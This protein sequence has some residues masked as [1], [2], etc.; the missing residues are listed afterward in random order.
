MSFIQSFDAYL[1]KTQTAETKQL[2]G[3]KCW[4]GSYMAHW[5]KS[6]RGRN[7]VP[8]GGN[9]IGTAYRNFLKENSLEEP[10]ANKLLEIYHWLDQ[11]PD[12][13]PDYAYQM[14]DEIK[15]W[16]RSGSLSNELFL[17]MN[18]FFVSSFESFLEVKIRQFESDNDEI[19]VIHNFKHLV[20]KFVNRSFSVE[21]E[22]RED[23]VFAFV[24]SLT[25]ENH[26]LF[27]YL[28]PLVKDFAIMFRSS[29]SEL[30]DKD[31]D[32]EDAGDSMGA[33]LFDSL[34][35]RIDNWQVVLK[36]FYAEVFDGPRAISSTFRYWKKN[37]SLPLLI[38][39]M[40]SCMM[41]K[42][43]TEKGYSAVTY[44]S[45]TGY[46]QVTLNAGFDSVVKG[47][48]DNVINYKISTSM[49]RDGLIEPRAI[50]SRDSN[51]KLD[52]FETLFQQEYEALVLGQI[53]FE[54]SLDLRYGSDQEFGNSRPGVIE[55]ISQYQVR[56]WDSGGIPTSINAFKLMRKP[57]TT[58]VSQGFTNAPI[59]SSGYIH[60][61]N[62][63]QELPRDMSGKIILASSAGTEYRKVVLSWGTKYAPAG[64]LSK[65][66][67][68]T[69]HVPAVLAGVMLCGV[70]VND[71]NL[72]HG[73][74]VTCV[75]DGGQ[76]RV[77]KEDIPFEAQKIPFADIPKTIIKTG[78][79]LTNAGWCD[80]DA[81]LPDVAKVS[82][83]RW[84]MGESGLIMDKQQVLPMPCYLYYSIMPENIKKIIDIQ[85][86]GLDPIEFY[87]LVMV[88][89]FGGVLDSFRGK[90]VNLRL[91]D[92]RVPAEANFYLPDSIFKNPDNP[93]A[94]LSGARLITQ[95]GEL[96]NQILAVVGE[97]FSEL[98]IRGFK[99]F[100]PMLPNVCYADLDAVPIVN[101]L[102]SRGISPQEFDYVCMDEVPELSGTDIHGNPIEYF[103]L[104]D[105][106]FK[107]LSEGN[108]DQSTAQSKIARDQTPLYHVHMAS[109]PNTFGRYYRKVENANKAGLVL[110]SCGNAHPALM[111]TFQEVG[112]DSVGLPPGIAYNE[113]KK[114]LN[115][116]EKEL[117][118]NLP[119]AS[120][121]I[122][123]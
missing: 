98:K 35:A 34:P 82:L 111:R 91:P 67:S 20:Q 19:I 117:A 64:F 54:Q 119:L 100:C 25:G 62:S 109:H 39:N 88:E 31:N 69:A 8:I 42:D 58:H 1:G 49:Y 70:S 41:V 45:E 105:A 2:F 110:G 102:S 74:F 95:G 94:S 79:V 33:G 86:C 60:V 99:N 56:R 38:G 30:E 106:G 11:H 104:R 36:Y 121:S 90:P 12:E 28:F 115:A 27:K 87:S 71:D 81:Y 113:A 13:E 84:E 108:N 93:D 116:N 18:T 16:I 22:H 78:L 17:E 23:V 80:Q 97:I 6:N 107:H 50:R 73:D 51:R 75:C 122:Y 44:V 123:H 32:D 21:E 57:Q 76:V 118:S 10:I 120:K 46:V 96:G 68:I 72:K 40:P 65:T 15:H 101:Y 9:L 85:R 7:A 26:K 24:V 83:F 29:F 53:A 37:G 3:G 103:K 61:V 89:V 5:W 14:A 59:I 63:A 77:Y 92:W 43:R 52:C 112:F 48:D 114:L 4:S 66:G 55:K 47:D